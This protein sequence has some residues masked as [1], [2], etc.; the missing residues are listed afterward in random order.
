MLS[1]PAF[2]L[3]RQLGRREGG[4]VEDEDLRTALTGMT[5]DRAEARI[6]A[7]LVGR[8]AR[9]LQVPEAS[10]AV[11]KPASEL[12]IDS[13]MGVE[14]G[15][16]LQEALGDD[17]P[18]TAVS[19]SLSI[20]EIGARII[21]HLHGEADA[22]GGEARTEIRVAVQHLAIAQDAAGAAEAAE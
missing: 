16:T 14:L 2:A 17:I 21:R 6:R 9:I 22:G 5:R 11:T 10:V 3:L 12:G 18:T 4:D 19:D 7:W 20:D 13:L 8:I 15:L 1:E